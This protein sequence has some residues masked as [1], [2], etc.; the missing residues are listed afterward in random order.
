M[1]GGG[2]NYFFSLCKTKPLD[3]AQLYDRAHTNGA[4]SGAFEV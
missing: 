4:A 2:K 3:I 1:R